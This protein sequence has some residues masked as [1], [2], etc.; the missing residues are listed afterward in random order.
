MGAKMPVT[1]ARLVGD[2]PSCDETNFE[3]SSFSHHSSYFC[4]PRRGT[5][6]CR[7]RIGSIIATS[8][9]RRCNTQGP[10]QTRVGDR[11]RFVPREP[12]DELALA[13]R[14]R[15]RARCEKEI[16]QIE[17]YM[18]PRRMNVDVKDT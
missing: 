2:I 7:A 6:A 1:N 5:R 11:E 9:S 4:A 16:T 13:W 3:T 14:G 17:M 18:H 12:A 8:A 10:D 15:G